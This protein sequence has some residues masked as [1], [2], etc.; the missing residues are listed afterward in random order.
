MKRLLAAFILIFSGTAQAAP[1]RIV[2][3][4]YCAD[5]F[6][7]G[8]ADRSQI[9]ALSMDSKRPFSYLGAEARGLPQVRADAEAVL[10]LKPDLVVRAWGGDPKLMRF[11]E[12]LKIET[13]EIGY[14]ENVEGAF[15][16]TRQAGV[17]FG[18]ETKAE[19]LIAAM[20]AAQ[21]PTGQAAFYLTP[22]GVTA[23]R[24]S[25]VDSIMTRA[26]LDNAETKTGWTSY[27]LED[28]V[29][30][31]PK[32]IL[33]AFFGFDTDR[34]D[35]WSPSRH[36]VLGRILADATVVEINEARVSCPAWF[37]AEE[38]AALAQKIDRTK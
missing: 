23:G 27:A 7:L 17:A 11:L 20:P 19:Q 34:R 31:P 2:S 8:L 9:A 30:S 25:M 18:R 10:A 29:R 37:V 1:Q 36:P 5:Q 28:L 21:T 38:S 14:A 35:A 22:G 3:L 32:F 33:S 16:L 6:V 12:R 13:H 4:D 26:G 24:G 15:E